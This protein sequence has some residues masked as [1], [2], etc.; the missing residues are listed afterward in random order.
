MKR[1]QNNSAL[2]LAVVAALLLDGCGGRDTTAPV[3]E[4][5]G[6]S[7]RKAAPAAPRGTPRGGDYTVQ[8]G[9][10]LYS[11]AWRYGRDYRELAA[12]NGIRPPYTIYVG[13][14]LRTAPGAPSTAARAPVRESAPAPAAPA[15]S[16]TPRAAPAPDTRGA[17][18]PRASASKPDPASV[19]GTVVF[20]RNVTW[21][22]P[23]EGPLLS[24]FSD[25]GSGRRGVDIGGHYGQPVRTAAAGQV[26]YSGS[27]L[28]GYGQLIIVKHND[29]YLSA[30]A[31]NRRLLVKEGEA[32]K[33]GQ[34][35]AEMGRSETDRVMLHFEIRKE[36]K[37]V[38]PLGYLPRR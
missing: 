10:T 29:M 13:Q 3:T 14:R 25:S 26:V 35:V 11:I 6:A 23:V 27:G 32:V 33:A 34:V 1:W 7:V 21:A 12:W 30:Y 28:R 9:D 22:W 18:P 17:A 38:D 19:S 16:A 15:R 37:P 4:R 24:R 2:A 31:H 20:P 5:Y 8:R 36:G